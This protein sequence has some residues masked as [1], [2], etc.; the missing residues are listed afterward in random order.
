MRGCEMSTYK[1]AS[2]ELG[3]I[4]R[5]EILRDISKT[6]HSI[7][8]LHARQNR[9]PRMRSLLRFL[10]LFAAV[11]LCVCYDSHE[12]TESAEDPFW[13]PN[14]A[15]S[16]MPQRN[17]IYNLPNR[18]PFRP[19]RRNIKPQSEI[20]A[21]ICEDFS[22]CHLYAYRFGFPQAYQRYF[23]HGLPSQQLYRPTGIRPY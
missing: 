15:N 1:V 8:V 20:R 13:T 4:P 5:E 19:F 18:G 10:A 16:F 21:E 22:P 6:S 9:S 3:N 2:G 12:S 23:R 17:N 11:S 7:P 14:R